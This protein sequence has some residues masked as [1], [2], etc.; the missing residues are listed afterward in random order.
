MPLAFRLIVSQTNFLDSPLDETTF[1]WPLHPRFYDGCTMHWIDKLF[2]E[3]EIRH[4]QLRCENTLYVMSRRVSLCVL[5]ADRLLNETQQS[6]WRSKALRDPASTVI[7][8]LP[9][10]PLLLPSFLSPIEVGPLNPD[11]RS[12][13]RCKLPQRGQ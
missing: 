2:D 10:P 3:A 7:L 4:T 11:I 9:F 12:G 8:G 6:Q 1:G 5:R 13:E